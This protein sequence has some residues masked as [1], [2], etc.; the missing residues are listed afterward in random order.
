[1]FTVR[2]FVVQ[3]HKP[4]QRG[5]GALNSLPGKVHRATVVSGQKPVSQRPGEEAAVAKAVQVHSVAERLTDFFALYGDVGIM[6]PIAGKLFAGRRFG[7]CYLVVV[8]N[9]DKVN[10]AHVYVDLPTQEC[11]YHC[12]TL[13]MPPGEAKPPGRLPAKFFITLP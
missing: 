3:A 6:D 7:L 11:K 4:D 13:G 5:I 10:A 2:H 12:Y 1:M 8:M 9:G